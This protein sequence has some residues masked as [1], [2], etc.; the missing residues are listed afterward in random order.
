[1]VYAPPTLRSLYLATPELEHDPPLDD[2][3]EEL[4]VDYLHIDDLIIYVSR[5]LLFLFINILR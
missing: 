5:Q 2:E 3:G 1:M 4:D